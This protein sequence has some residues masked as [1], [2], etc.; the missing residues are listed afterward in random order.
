MNL[1][2]DQ[3]LKYHSEGSIATREAAQRVLQATT[4]DNLKEVRQRLEADP[5]LRQQ[6]DELCEEWQDLTDEQ[7][8]KFITVES[9]CN[10]G[11]ITEEHIKAR[12]AR[13]KEEHRKMRD[14]VRL[15]N[16]FEPDWI[17]PTGDTVYACM[18]EQGKSISDLADGLGK[19]VTWCAHFLTGG[20]VVDED[21]AEKLAKMFGSTKA[22]WLKRDKT[23]QEGL[24][25]L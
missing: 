2:L 6:V 16:S 23:Y 14:G 4:R 24:S 3:I 12:E 10:S 11:P 8:D 13:H 17:S 9:W 25:K 20:K 21:V 15:L 22:F 5:W 1:T 19:D 18:R 7:W